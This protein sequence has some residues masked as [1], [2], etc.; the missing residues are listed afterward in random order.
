MLNRWLQIVSGSRT[1][2]LSQVSFNSYDICDFET[3]ILISNVLKIF[4]QLQ[5]SLDERVYIASFLSSS[6]PTW[7]STSNKISIISTKRTV[8]RY[9]FGIAVPSHWNLLPN[10][11]TA[12]SNL[13]SF[14]TEL[15]AFISSRLI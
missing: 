1:S 14:K 3:Q 11:I 7:A 4:Y 6:Y 9:C 5:L 8:D 12:I 15:R 13:N 2:T 10:E